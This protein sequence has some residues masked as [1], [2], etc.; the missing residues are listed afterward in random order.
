M[1]VLPPHHNNTANLGRF[2]VDKHLRN[3]QK[4]RNAARKVWEQKKLQKSEVRRNLKKRY[5]SK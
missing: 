3:L 5:V 4:I 1:A 2:A